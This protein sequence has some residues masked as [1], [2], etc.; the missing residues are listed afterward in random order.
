MSSLRPRILRVPVSSSQASEKVYKMM[1]GPAGIALRQI[2]AWSWRLNQCSA[3]FQNQRF[4]TEL[5][6]L[7]IGGREMWN[8]ARSRLL[9][10]WESH[11]K[12]R[13]E[14][15]NCCGW[16]GTKTSR[17]ADLGLVSIYLLFFG[18]NP[19]FKRFPLQLLNHLCA[20]STPSHRPAQHSNIA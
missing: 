19:D 10:L 6:K 1:Q 18:A 2:H 13:S 20:M 3:A 12:P 4:C 8:A 14:Q 9:P 11:R 17:G 5:W 16:C 7:D 15:K